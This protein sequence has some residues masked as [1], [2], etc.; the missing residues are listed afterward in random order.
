MLTIIKILFVLE[1]INLLLIPF[2]ELERINQTVQSFGNLGTIIDA[3]FEIIILASFFS[4]DFFP[5]IMAAV[6]VITLELS[7]KF[8]LIATG[9]QIKKQSFA[10]FSLK[11]IVVLG[12]VI[13]VK[14]GY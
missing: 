1:F 2:R 6:L 8:K 4:M 14:G 5:I 12:I 13:V 3:L 10:L 11:S 7:E 9:E